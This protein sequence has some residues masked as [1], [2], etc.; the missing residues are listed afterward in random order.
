M[1]MNNE[2]PV[3][4]PIVEQVA[5]RIHALRDVLEMARAVYVVHYDSVVLRLEGE[6]YNHAE[7]LEAVCLRI[8]REHNFDDL[9]D[10]FDELWF[11][12]NDL[13][14]EFGHHCL[15]LGIFLSDWECLVIREDGTTSSSSEDDEAASSE[16]EEVEINVD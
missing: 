6:L 10:Q 16:G 8:A 14:L 11:K 4:E 1:D 7:Q 9:Q 15:S 13:F 12:L 2:Y 5:S 3:V